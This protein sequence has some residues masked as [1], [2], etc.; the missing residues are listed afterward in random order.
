M[1]FN[2]LLALVAV[3]VFGASTAMAQTPAPP[4]CNPTYP[5]WGDYGLTLAWSATPNVCENTGRFLTDGFIDEAPGAKG[6]LLGAQIVNRPGDNTPVSCRFTFARETN[7]KCSPGPKSRSQCVTSG[8]GF[9]EFATIE[10]FPGACIYCVR[11][12][13]CGWAPTQ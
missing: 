8:A 12:D 6:N 13:A 2:S 9:V 10:R 7:G 5:G 11:G 1:Q 3:T 4:G